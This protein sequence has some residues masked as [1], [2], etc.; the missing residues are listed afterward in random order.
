M[1]TFDLGKVVGDK[2]DKGDTGATGA[3][4][5][6]ISGISLVGTSGKTKTYRISFT[7]GSHFD[8][9]VNDG[10]DGSGDVVTSWESTLSDTKVPSE[11]L[12]KNSL[13]AKAGTSHTHTKSQI[14]DFP[15]IPSKISDLT[16]DSD[17]IETSSTAGLVKNDG[18][19][20][21]T[22]YLSNSS[23]SSTYI[24]K[25]DIVDNLSTNDATKVLSA[26]QGKALADLIGTAISY[27]NQ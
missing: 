15:T 11:K 24:P 1:A 16:D 8:F 26:K 2:G 17:F 20:D 23:A 10:N 13:D 6:G 12:V 3:T 22:S 18:S 4:G 27:I 7:D 9:E 5:N 19:I 25:S 21:T 14:T